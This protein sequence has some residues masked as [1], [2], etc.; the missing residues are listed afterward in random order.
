MAG[1][2]GSGG[3]NPRKFSEK[4]ALHN[5]KQAEETRAFEQLMTDITLSRDLLQLQ[6]EGVAV[7]KLFD[8]ATVN[9]NLLIFL[10]NK[11][12]YGKQRRKAELVKL[13]QTNGALNSK[14]SFYAVQ[15]DYYNQYIKTCMDNLA[16]K[17]KVSKKPGQVKKSKQVSQKYTAARLHEKG[18]LMEIED[19]QT[20]HAPTRVRYLASRNFFS[21]LG[22]SWLRLRRNHRSTCRTEQPVFLHSASTSAWTGERHTH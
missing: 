11:K 15:I 6:Y 2:P 1:S 16:S 3:T 13:Q 8:R 7:M 4:I 18:V 22:R 19:L 9:V 17:G 20:N 12:F 10:L 5:Q 21:R 14:S